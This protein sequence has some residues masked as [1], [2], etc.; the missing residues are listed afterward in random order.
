MLAFE[1]LKQITGM[2]LAFHPEKHIG[3]RKASVRKWR[4][5]LSSG[6]IAY[7]KVPEVIRL[8]ESFEAERAADN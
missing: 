3:Q 7:K 8:L 5:R 4:G 1:N 6:Q 2:T